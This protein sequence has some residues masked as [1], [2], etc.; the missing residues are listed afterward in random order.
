MPAVSAHNRPRRPKLQLRWLDSRIVL[1]TEN[2]RPAVTKGNWW[3]GVLIVAAVAGGIIA[4]VLTD[5]SA[6]Q[7]SGLSKEFQYQ[8]DEYKKIPPAMLAYK[9]T[10]EFP[11]EMRE[12]RA[13]AIDSG[14]RIHVAGDRTV[15]VFASDGKPQSR[16]TLED[17]PYCLAIGDAEHAFAGRIY[18]G[19]KDRLLLFDENGRPAGSWDSL[20]DR[21]LLTSI[22]LAEDDVFA[23]DAGNAVVV[24]YDTSGKIVGQ[25]GKPDKERGISGFAIPSPFFDVAVHPDGW[26][27][28][29]NPG[30]LRIEAYSF[31]GNLELYWGKRTNELDGFFGCCNPANFAIL[32]DGR[33]VTAEKGLLRVKI[34]STHGELECVVAGPQEFDSSPTAVVDE[35]LADHEYTAVDVAIDSAQR[36]VVLDRPGQRVRIFEPKASEEVT[37]P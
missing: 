30:A 33:F 31:D 26:L 5:P 22:A 19:L 10:A 11:V 15:A 29:V 18:V 2:N 17:E 8:I 24:R 3:I 27:S 9:Q 13:V 36:I 32:P 20:G 14:D 37:P 1:V 4:L 28:V 25:I 7:G 34:Y 23:A 35:S 12:A 21:A 16:I 6:K